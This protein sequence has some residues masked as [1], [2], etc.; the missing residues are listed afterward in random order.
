MKNRDMYNTSGC[1]DPTPY[2][3]LRNIERTEKTRSK[4]IGVIRGHV[5]IGRTIRSYHSLQTVGR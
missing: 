3:A 2:Y 4:R 5:N 1:Y